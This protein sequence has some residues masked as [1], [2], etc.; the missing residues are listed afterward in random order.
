ML[1]TAE[2]ITKSFLDDVVLSGVSLEVQAGDRIGLLGANGAG[3]TTLLNILAG[4]LTPDEGMVHRA[5][6]LS[7]G[8]VRQNDALDSERTLDE[9]IRNAFASA[10]AVLAE[11]EATGK[12]LAEAPGDTA[13]L[14]AY[15]KLQARFEAMDGYRI[16]EKINRV[17]GGLGFAGFD[18]HGT[19]VQTLSGGEKMRFAFAKVLLRAPDV[20]LLDEPTNHLDFSMLA[21]LEDYLSTYK[22]AVVVVSHD[23]YFLDAIAKDICEVERHTLT[24]YTGGYTSFVVQKAERR[25]AAERAW[26]KQQVEIAKMEDYVRRNLVRASTTKMAQSR[27]NALEKMERL[28]KPPPEGKTISL[29]FEYDVE[30]FQMILQCENLGVTVGEG[31]TA[32]RLYEGINLEVR[33]GEKIA[34]VGLNGVGKSTFLKAIQ[35]L[36]PHDGAARW[37][38]NV[39]LGYFDQELAGLPMDE[40]VLEAVHSVYPAKTEFEIRSALGRLLLEGETVFKKVRELSGAMRAKVAFAILQM[41]RANVLLLDEPTNHLDYRAKEVLE[42]TLQ[43]FD[44]TLIVVSHDRYFLQ[45]VPSSILEMTPEGFFRVEGNY[46]AYKAARALAPP[47]APAPHGEADAGDAPPE[48]KGGN[49]RSKKQRAEDAQR[50]VRIA[51]QEREIALLEGRIAEANQQLADPANASDYELLTELSEQLK[52]DGTALEEI[53]DQWLALTSEE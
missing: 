4:N 21:W 31:D 16:D 2:N 51:E 6:H 14:A 49:Y 43:G 48:E 3:K 12:R 9:E 7:V 39:R 50:R 44:G 15:D 37:G 1:I 22:G 53:M 52:T 47:K 35:N 18:R 30:P 33:R 40:T 10:W 13:L 26:E 20:L 28:P 32:R 19:R 17:L 5:K 24:R 45:K 34:L 41:R 27:R 23:R 8:Y 29:K 42:Q 36:M 38:G 46:D 11:L 25:R